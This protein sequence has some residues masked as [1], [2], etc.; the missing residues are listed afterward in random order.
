MEKPVSSNQSTRKK[1]KKNGPLNRP[2]K[3]Y[4]SLYGETSEFKPDP[5][6]KKKNGHILENCRERTTE[7]F[8]EPNSITR[9]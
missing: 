9:Y 8:C 5:W 2:P 3:K 7:G 1:K 4:F 6:E